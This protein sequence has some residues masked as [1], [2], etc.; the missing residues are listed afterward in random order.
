[1][2]MRNPRLSPETG[3]PAT[4]EPCPLHIWKHEVIV[5]SSMPAID[6]AEWQQTMNAR[7][8][9]WY[10][11]GEPVWMAASSLLQFA[12]GYQRAQR[13]DREVIRAAHRAAKNI[14]Y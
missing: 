1:M 2:T 10:R 4:S 5:D 3:N 9:S 12:I 8:I 14:I 13:D 11:A 6:D 7:L